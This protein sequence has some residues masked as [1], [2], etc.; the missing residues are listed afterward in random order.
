MKNYEPFTTVKYIFYLFF[1]S[2]IRDGSRRAG[3]YVPFTRHPVAPNAAFPLARA[4]VG[5]RFD[6]QASIER[7]SMPE[8]IMP[9]YGISCQSLFE[10]PNFSAGPFP[11]RRQLS[12]RFRETRVNPRS[13][14]ENKT[15]EA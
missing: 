8:S 6:R 3:N 5:F 2:F 9:V 13:T 1:F 7:G 12:W 14:M 4:T 15:V 11:P 10:I